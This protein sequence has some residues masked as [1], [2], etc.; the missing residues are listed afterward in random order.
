MCSSERKKPKG[1]TYTGTS[2]A[3]NTGSRVML[4]KRWQDVITLLFGVWLIVSP[5]VLPRSLE[6]HTLVNHSLAIGAV[7]MAAA[8]W[9]IARPNAWKEWVIAF[10]GAWLIAATYTLPPG[11]HFSGSLSAIADNMVIV[12]LLILVD[13]AFGLYRR[14]AIN[15]MDKPRAA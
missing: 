15:D 4:K 9:A 7:L 11:M 13:A 1:D 3:K 14:Q 6:D 8:L 2:D 5:F 10:L 12:G